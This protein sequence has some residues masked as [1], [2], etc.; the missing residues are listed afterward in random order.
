MKILMVCLGNICRSPIAEGILRHKL[1]VMKNED[2]Q[3]DSAGTSNFHV[4]EQPDSRMRMT[5]VKNGMDISDLRARQFVQSDFDEFDLIYAMDNANKMDILK[6][7]RNDADR[8]KVKLILD[9][10][11]PGENREV[12][13]PYYGGDE[14]FQQVF[15]MLDDA[16]D[17]LIARYID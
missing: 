11:Y 7:A 2:V 15:D 10:I 8:A 6:L 5:A 3:T 12:P 1:R 13:D 14:G 9:E 16:T 4:G 17:Q